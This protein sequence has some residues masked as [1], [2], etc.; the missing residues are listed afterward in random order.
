MRRA[1]RGVRGE[2]NGQIMCQE[3]SQGI[4]SGL[5]N[6]TR[7]ECVVAMANN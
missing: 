5:R 1:K 2:G 4:V 6:Q 3:Q 7:W